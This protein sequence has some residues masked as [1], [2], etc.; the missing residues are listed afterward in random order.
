M[1]VPE[2]AARPVTVETALATIVSTEARKESRGAHDRS[3]YPDRPGYE[4]G[5]DDKE[6][7]KHSLWYMT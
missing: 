2:P 1:S 4:N 3:D 6:W 7:L 5:R